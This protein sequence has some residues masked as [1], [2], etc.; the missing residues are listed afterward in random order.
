M[1]S[2]LLQVRADASC[3]CGVNTLLYY[4]CGLHGALHDFAS[5]SEASTLHQLRTLKGFMLDG[6]SEAVHGTLSATQYP[7]G[8]CRTLLA[9]QY[10]PARSVSANCQFEFSKKSLRFCA[11]LHLGFIAL[12]PFPSTQKCRVECGHG[13]A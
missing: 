5:P 1:S 2:F 9:Y 3:L 10:L 12:N 6:V 7:R 8:Y 11:L 4:V 13:Q